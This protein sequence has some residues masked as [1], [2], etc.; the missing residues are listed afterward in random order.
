M[1]TSFMMLCLTL[2]CLES[3][4]YAEEEKA[5]SE[6]T[7]RGSYGFVATGFTP[8][9]PQPGAVV[10]QG[11]FLGIRKFDGQGNFTGT[12]SIKTVNMPAILDLPVSGT[13][14][15]NADCTGTAF[16]S[17]PGQPRPAE[18]RLVVTKKGKEVFW[19]LVSPDGPMTQA[20]GV[21]I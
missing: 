6:R 11:F 8:A 4:L 2:A 13:Y 17:T 10:S 12:D 7:L 16:M 3:A 1:R 21:R 18:L 19:I 9:N 14:K 15:I 5:C 20:H